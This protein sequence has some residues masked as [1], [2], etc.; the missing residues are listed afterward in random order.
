[1]LGNTTKKNINWQMIF[2]V[3][4]IV[5]LPLGS[6]LVNM[7]GAEKGRAFYKDLRDSLGRIPAFNLTGWQNEAV[8]T[9]GVKSTVVVA[10]YI[11]DA[12]K[13][14]ILNTVKTVSKIP[15]FREEI[16]NLTYLT[17]DLSSDST[18][19]KNYIQ[20]FNPKDKEIWHIL[21]GGREA[22]NNIKFPNEYNIALIDTVGTIRRFYDA[23]N[24][25]DKKKLVEHISVMPIRKEEKKVVKKNQKQM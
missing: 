6:L 16:D 2:I 9:E 5:L 23:R 22:V 18:F 7:K 12:N 11:N 24:A 19:V 17:F 8:L 15:Q 20:D 21:R 25:D 1:M 10:S 4:V 3:G 14:V 13:D